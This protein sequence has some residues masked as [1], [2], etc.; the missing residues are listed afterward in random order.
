MEAIMTPTAM[1]VP[2]SWGISEADAALARERSRTQLAASL[3][4]LVGKLTQLPSHDECRRI[5]GGGPDQLVVFH[6]GQWA[7]AH[8]GEV[9]PLVLDKEH[10]LPEVL[11]QARG[12]FLKI[13]EE[14]VQK[15]HLRPHLDEAQVQIVMDEVFRLKLAEARKKANQEKEAKR[16]KRKELVLNSIILPV[17]LAILTTLITLKLTQWLTAPSEPANPAQ[18]ASP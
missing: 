14:Y 7:E 5:Y 2:A 15:M 3:G 6:L 18:K 11:N 4:Q 12:I 1:G 17:F 8:F 13:E 16:Q 9:I 10:L